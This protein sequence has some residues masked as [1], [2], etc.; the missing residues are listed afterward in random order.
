MCQGFLCL[1]LCMNKMYLDDNSV[2]NNLD[3]GTW[4]ANNNQV[5]LVTIGIINQN[6]FLLFLSIF[7][8]TSWSGS[9]ILIKQHIT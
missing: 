4:I 5:K 3:K 8:Y 9:E 1:L 6:I 2:C 7:W